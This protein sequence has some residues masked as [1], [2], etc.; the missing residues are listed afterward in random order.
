[1]DDIMKAVV[2]M[3]REGGPLALWAVVLFQIKY[4]LKY[5]CLAFVLTFI[6]R[7]IRRI[8]ESICNHDLRCEE[9][10]REKK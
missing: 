10:R 4:L 8:I 2:E 7:Q 1:M 9:I 3:V 5:L 6:I